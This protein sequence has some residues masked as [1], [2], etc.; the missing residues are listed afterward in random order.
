MGYEIMD[1]GNGYFMVKFDAPEDHEKVIAG[2]PWMIQDHYLTIKRWT[3]DF[4]PCESCFGRTFV[5]IR[6]SGP[7]L[8]YYEE[9]A[10][11]TIAFAVGKL[12]KVDFNTKLVGKGRFARI[13]VERDLATPVVDEVWITNHLHKV[14]FLKVCI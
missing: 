11:K 2:G 8:M 14:D 13:Y 6:L 5:W 3:Q 4:N 1:V 10:I 7:N 12:I 9:I